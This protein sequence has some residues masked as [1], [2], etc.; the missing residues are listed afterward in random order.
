MAPGMHDPDTRRNLTGN[1]IGILSYHPVTTRQMREHGTQFCLG[2]SPGYKYFDLCYSFKALVHL[3]YG[4][5]QRLHE[6][7]WNYR[8]NWAKV[9]GTGPDVRMSYEKV[10]RNLIVFMF[11]YY[12]NAF[13]CHGAR[14]GHWA[15]LALRCFMVAAQLGRFHCWYKQADLR[16]PEVMKTWWK[17]L[18]HEPQDDCRSSY[19]STLAA[20][21]SP[22]Q[23]SYGHPKL[24]GRYY[25]HVY[26]QSRHIGQ[27]TQK[28][29][30]DS[31]DYNE[32]VYNQVLGELLSYLQGSEHLN[33]PTRSDPG[34]SSLLNPEIVLPEE[35][36]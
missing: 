27:L 21:G 20:M 18:P 7:A 30:D 29:W 35:K 17:E 23:P 24:L 28:K 34:P 2:E 31:T 10:L 11:G 4:S 22:K 12:I 14:K 9:F 3:E 5:V 33:Y 1:Y 32:S 19:N 25:N 26:H 8:N 15:I 36:F 6:A 13:E 16:K